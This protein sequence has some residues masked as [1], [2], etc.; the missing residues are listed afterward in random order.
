MVYQKN[1]KPQQVMS[2]AS[3]LVTCATSQQAPKKDV[4][5]KRKKRN[6]GGENHQKAVKKEEQT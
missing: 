1:L 6:K 5:N 4:K 2:P 3:K